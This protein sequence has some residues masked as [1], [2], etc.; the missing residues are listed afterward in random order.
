MVDGESTC[1]QML[2]LHIGAS[3]TTPANPNAMLFHSLRNSIQ[4]VSTYYLYE[5]RSAFISTKSYSKY[6]LSSW[7]PLHLC[8]WKTRRIYAGNSTEVIVDFL[9][10]RGKSQ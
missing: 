10:T 8:L 3:E 4:T 2:T 1:N 9:L 6:F 5:R 7:N